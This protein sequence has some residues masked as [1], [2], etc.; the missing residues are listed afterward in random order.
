MI[1]ELMEDKRKRIPSCPKK[2]KLFSESVGEKE[3]NCPG[4]IC[5]PKGL[6]S[7]LKAASGIY[8]YDL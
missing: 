7:I 2:E 4:C 8:F 3:E 1:Y 6:S 5:Y